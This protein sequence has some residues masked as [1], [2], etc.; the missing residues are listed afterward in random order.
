MSMP[1]SA[2]SFPRRIAVDRR[3]PARAR[4]APIVAMLCLWAAP[5]PEASAVE[6]HYDVLVTSLSGTLVTGGFSHADLSAVAPLRV[7]KGESLGIGPADPYQSAEEPGFEAAGQAF[8][9]GGAMTPSGVYAALP[10]NSA[11]GFAFQPITI[12]AATRNLFF[13]DGAGGV[14]FAPLTGTDTLALIRSGFGG[15]TRT[16]TGTSAGVVNGATIDTTDGAGELHKHLT[17]EIASGAAGAATG[18]YLFALQ[19]QMGG[20]AP[21]ADAY[22]VYGA[23]DT[24][25]PPDLVAFE[26]AHDAAVDWVGASLL[27]PE[28][29]TTWLAASGVA[30]LFTLLHLRRRRSVAGGRGRD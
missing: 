11:L 15:W 12:G 4:L 16:I 19:F 30:G 18:F 26:A 8:L 27:V 5:G 20:L 9:D 2:L 3:T 24:E 13:W 6:V 17:T 25:N 7:F 21:A 23:Y 22:F 1:S 28:P 10:A 29:G 14:N